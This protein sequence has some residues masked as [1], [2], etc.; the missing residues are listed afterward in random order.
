MPTLRRSF[1]LGAGTL[2]LGACA[3]QPPRAR[4]A[5]L[6][7]AH[8]GI[9][10]F[11]AARIDLVNEYRAPMAA[12]N[13]EHLFATMPEIVM[14]RWATDRLRT[15]GAPSHYMVFTILDARVVETSLPRTPGVRGALT[16]DQ[17]E[18]YD[19]S[20]AASLEIRQDRVGFQDAFARAQSTRSRSVAENATLNE[21]EQVWYDLIEQT[22]TE[23]D[24]ELDRQIREN[25][26][27]FLR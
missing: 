1:V 18:R 6:T 22:M 15:T 4:F 7:Y 26:R 14:R 13:V 21:R 11:E 19:A 17:T 27:R 5:D 12:P 16:T 20:L 3:T 10:T 8:R 9:L 2:A 23:L 24:R 25:F